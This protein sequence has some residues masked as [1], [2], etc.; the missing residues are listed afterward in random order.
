MLFL[1]EY[2]HIYTNNGILILSKIVLQIFSLM[3]NTADHETVLD[4]EKINVQ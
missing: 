1:F 4:V 3:Y 2:K